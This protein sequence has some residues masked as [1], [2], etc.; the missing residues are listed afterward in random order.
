[1][2]AK[3]VLKKAQ[4]LYNKGEWQEAI[5]A[6]DENL[7]TLVTD[8]DITEA[9][10]IKG[11]SYYYLGIK[12]PKDKKTENLEEAENTFK[13]VLEKAEDKTRISAMNGLPLALWILGKKEEAWQVS[14]KATEEFPDIP[15]IWNTRSILCRWAQDYEKAVEVCEKVYETAIEKEDYRTAG[16]GKHNKADALVKLGRA[17]EARHEYKEAIELYKKYEKATGQSAKFHIEGVQK[18]LANL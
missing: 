12:G 3:E 6:I 10:R 16:H 11:W 2:E 18:K 5:D 1:M 4:Q 17:E 7:A 8:S 15:S 14:D 9:N 13:A